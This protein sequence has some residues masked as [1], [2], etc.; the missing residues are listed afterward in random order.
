MI[1]DVEEP[2]TDDPTGDSPG[3]NCRDNVCR[4]AATTAEP[5]RQPHRGA[6]RKCGENPMPAQLEWADLGD[7]RV[8]ADID[9]DHPIASVTSLV[10][11]L[12][13][14]RNKAITIR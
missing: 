5:Y 2:R 10:D 7:D 11:W 9:G 13:A 14:R 4:D 1:E 8:E 12:I 6:Y 3:R